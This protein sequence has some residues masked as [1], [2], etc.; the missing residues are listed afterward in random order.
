MTFN[1]AVK[2]RSAS[3]CYYYFC[4]MSGTKT[5]AEARWDNDVLSFSVTE[6]TLTSDGV[7]IELCSGSIGAQDLVASGT[8]PGHITMQLICRLRSERLERGHRS[9]DNAAGEDSTAAV[10]ATT[11]SSLAVEVRLF[12]NTGGKDAGVCTLNL[13]FRPDREDETANSVPCMWGHQMQAEAQ[14]ESE[15]SAMV[16]A[17]RVVAVPAVAA[18]AAEVR[19]DWLVKGMDHHKS[20]LV[21]LEETARHIEEIKEVQFR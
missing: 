11:S 4:R 2:G 3:K 8:I 1:S 6:Q 10:P 18:R 16:S 12:D 20:S 15:A 17:P 13:N 21:L 9:T 14:R 5:G 19:A 7:L